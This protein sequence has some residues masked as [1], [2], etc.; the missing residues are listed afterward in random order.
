MDVQ[1]SLTDGIPVLALNGRFDGFGALQFDGVTQDLRSAAPFWVLDCSGVTYISSI[2]LRSLVALEKTLRAH[3]GGLILVGVTRSVRQLLEMTR[4]D[5]WLRFM[6]TVSDGLQMA[7]VADVGP[8]AEHHVCGR[9][10]RV[11]RVAA[12]SS[13]L[14]WWNGTPDGQL[15][16]VSL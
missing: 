9:A 14:E 6:P 3:D 16:S 1:V 10:V 15:V 5:G 13:S 8:V 11:R 2:G 7:R 12:G 4:L